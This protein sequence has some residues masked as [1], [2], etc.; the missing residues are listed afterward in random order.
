MTFAIVAMLAGMAIMFPVMVLRFVSRYRIPLAACTFL[1][2]VGFGVIF[3]LPMLPASVLRNDE[4][5]NAGPTSLAVD[6]E[7]ALYVASGPLGRIQKY[8]SDGRF[9]YGWLVDNAGGHFGISL[10]EDGLIEMCASRRK[11]LARF[12]TDG[13]PVAIPSPP[14]CDTADP[15]FSRTEISGYRIDDFSLVPTITARNAD[16][17][18]RFTIWPPIWFLP[19]WS[20]FIA[21]LMIAIGF[22]PAV[23]GRK[24]ASRSQPAPS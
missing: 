18:K 5:P 4:F 8:S 23:L 15:R 24:R 10:G 20:P 14:A 22:L 17:S 3:W 21:W 12:D 16:G 2:V 7:G 9:R 19:L 1:G 11:H 6:R 13:R